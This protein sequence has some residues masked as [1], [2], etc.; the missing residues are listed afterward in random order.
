MDEKPQESNNSFPP[1]VTVLGHV[2]HGKTS[3]LDAIRKSNI[4]ASEHGGITQRIGASSIKTIHEG[5]ER[6]ITFIDTPG[7]ETFAKMRSRGVRVAD[8]ALLVVAAN[9]GVMPQTKESIQLLKASKIP[10]IVTITKSD[11]PEK[12]I[13]KVKQMLLKEAVLLEGMGGDVPVIEVSSKTNSNIK[14]LLDLILL[15]YEMQYPE[16]RKEADVTVSKESQFRGVIIESKLDS[17]S[18]PRAT[19]VIKNGTIAIRDE[20]IAESSPGRV[21][22]LINEDGKQV[23]HASIGQ[24]VE[25]LGFEKVPSVGSIVLK[26]GDTS[27]VKAEEK[28]EKKKESYSPYA[29]ESALSVIICADTVGSLE[30]IVE[31]LP[32]DLLILSQKTGEISEADVL[33]AKSVGG[34]A[35]GFNAKIRGEVAR[36][37]MQEKVLVKNYAIIYELIDEIS[38]ALAGKQLALEP[39]ILGKAKI[40]A[41][42]PFEKTK[43]LGI[44]VLEGRVA[45]GDKITLVRGEDTIGTSTITSV[46]QG[47]ETVSKVEKGK[48]AG[49]ILS[50]YLDFVTGDMVICQG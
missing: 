20:L 4:A 28:E 11:L 37:A 46:R 17:K 15:V 21:K 3:L 42:F 35:V 12:N 38:E 40:Q 27:E 23:Q 10:F 1:V 50:P 24:A 22:T 44:T 18:G 8:I 36:L 33:L 7:H 49:I 2:D 26:K 31:A 45:R 34:V 39:K 48:E 5:K 13:Q 43:V 6:T 14:E 9:D 16:G 30:A 41:S 19:M 25:I 47:K 29:K 32:K